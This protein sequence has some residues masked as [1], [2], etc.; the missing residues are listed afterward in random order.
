MSAGAVSAQTPLAERAP[1][2]WELRLVDGSGL[3]SV[4]LGAQQMFKNLPD[5]QRKQMER[6]MGGS[7]GLSLPTVLRQCVTPEQAR[8]DIQPQLAILDISCSALEWPGC[9]GHH[10]L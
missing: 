2:L 10:R 4:A 5:A 8:S 6:L 3:A 7:W 9:G 1:G